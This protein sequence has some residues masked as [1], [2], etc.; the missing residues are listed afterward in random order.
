MIR[1]KK[2]WYSK[3][4]YEVRRG[5]RIVLKGCDETVDWVARQEL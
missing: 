1:G 4:L 2:A 5:G 3:T